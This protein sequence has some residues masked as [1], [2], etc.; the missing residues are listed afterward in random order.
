MTKYEFYQLRAAECMKKAKESNDL[1]M[2]LFFENCAS[3]FKKKAEKLSIENA[4][5]III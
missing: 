3:G 4:E 5:Q 1:L 2:I